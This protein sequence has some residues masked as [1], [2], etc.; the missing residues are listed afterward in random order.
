MADCKIIFENGKKVGVE[1]IDGASSPL[2]QQILNNA[3]VNSFDEAVEIY[4]N[5]YND[6][7]LYSI[8]GEK[9][10]ITLDRLEETTFRLDNLRIAQEMETQGKNPSEIRTTTSWEKGADGK[11]KLEILEGKLKISE[12]EVGV[13]YNISDILT[14]SELTLL[15][16]NI[17]I[18]F[19]ENVHSANAKGGFNPN[20]GV[21]S[22]R[23]ETF[24][25]N[26]E[27]SRRRIKNDSDLLQTILHESQHYIQRIEGFG[28]GGNISTVPRE[29]QRIIDARPTDTSE[30]LKEKAQS[31]LLSDNITNNEKNI[32]Q[33]YLGILTT[34]EPLKEA[35]E[36][37]ERLAGEVEAENVVKRMFFED[38]LRKNQLLATSAEIPKSDQIVIFGDRTEPNLRYQTPNGQIFDS[39]QDALKNT[40]DG[41]IKGGVNTLNG[42]QEFFSVE[43]NTN[44]N[45]REGIINNLVKSG[46][47]T[48]ETYVDK[49]GLTYHKPNGNSI[50]KKA[51]NGAEVVE[52]IQKH[53]GLRAVKTK[54]N[55]DVHI[56]DNYNKVAITKKNGE[57]EYVEQS[58]L[59]Q[60]NWKQ[61]EDGIALL[62][63]QEHKT[64]VKGE[65][66]EQ[67]TFVPENELQQKLMKWLTQVGIKTTSM[68]DYVENYAKKNGV[69]P[70]ASA[71]ADIANQVVAFRDGVITTAD[72]SEETAHFII[73]SMPQSEKENMLRN[74]HKTREWAEHYQTYM[75]IYQDEAMVREEIL[76]KVLANG[77]QE[78]FNARNQNSTEDSILAKLAELFQ[79]F[80][81]RIQ[82]F[83]T[84]NHE[85]QLNKFTQ[86]V[87]A[88]LMAETL[89]LGALPKQGF[90]LF[91]VDQ[92]QADQATRL[93]NKTGEALDV[94]WAQ[95]NQLAKGRKLNATRDELKEAKR[96]NQEA[97]RLSKLKALSGVVLVAKKQITHLERALEKASTNNFPFTQEENAVYQTYIS[98]TETLLSEITALLDSGNSEENII[99]KQLVEVLGKGAQL[100]GIV[101]GRGNTAIQT[102]VDKVVLK[103]N[104]TSAQ[105]K[106]F[107]GFITASQKDTNFLMSHLGSL[108]SARNPL[109]NIAGDITNRIQVE[110]RE[111]YL[112]AVKG[113]TNAL[114]KAGVEPK[115]IK[116][117]IDESGQYLINELDFTAINTAENN[118]KLEVYNTMVKEPLTLEKFLDKESKGELGLDTNQQRQYNKKV[119]D[120]TSKWREPFFKESYLKEQESLFKDLPSEALDYHK[121]YRAQLAEIRVNATQDGVTI[122]DSNDKY[123]I[124]QLNKQRAYASNPRELTGEM[125]K[126]LMETYNPQTQE[127]ELNLDVD[128][129]NKDP[130]G[131]A[132]A[133]I[134]FGLNKIAE[135]T[136]KQYEGATRDSEIPQKFF[137]EINKLKTLEERIEFMFLN[138]YVGFND[139]FWE[140]FGSSEG[141]LQKLQNLNDIENDFLI[142]QIR[143]Q[144]QKIS[145]IQKANRVF[146]RPSE[147]NVAEMEGTEKDAIKEAVQDLEALYTQAN[148]LL[149]K[150]AQVDVETLFTSTVND[151]YT[152]MLQ[153]MNII[154]LDKE[155]D[156]IQRHTS[157]NNRQNILKAMR[158]AEMLRKDSDTEIPKTLQRVFTNGMNNAEIDQALLDYSRSKLLPYYKRTEPR[159]FS[160]VM[161]QLREG[162]IT[163]EEFTKSPLVKVSPNYSFY[164]TV[165]NDN[166]NPKFLENKKNGRAQIKEGLFE[167][168]KYKDYFDVQNGEATKNKDMWEVYKAVLELQKTTLDNMGMS[169]K[170][171]LYKLPQ[172]GKRGLRQWQDTL[173]ESSGRPW[174]EILK[175][176]TTWRTDELEFGVDN[177]QNTASKKMRANIIPMYYVRD[178]QDPKDVTDE[179]LYSYALM[180]QQSALY[181]AR[182]NNI[183]D[184]LAVKQ[185]ILNQDIQGK[186]ASTSQTYQ[187]FQS[188]MDFNLYGVK[189]NFSYEV[190]LLGTGKIVD[191]S[192]VAVTFNNIIK[193]INLT[194]LTIPVVSWTQGEVQRKIESIVG[195]RINPIAAKIANAEFRKLATPAAGEI[196]KINSKSKLNVLGEAFGLYNLGER[197][198]N[199]NYGKFTRGLDKASMATHTL[200]NFPI[201]PR[202]LLTVLHDARYYDGRIMSFNQFSRMKALETK[203][204]SKVELEWKSLDLFYEDIYVKDGVQEYDTA[205]IAT[206][207]GKNE[208]ETV[209][210]LK[211]YHEGL[212]SRV[213]AAVQDIDANIPQ[214]ERS[215]ASRH[216]VF[217]FF[218]THRN[219]LLLATAR[220]FKDKH[221]NLA[222]GELEEGSYLNTY[223]FMKEITMGYRKSEQATYLKHIKDVW[224]N[225]DETTRR[226]LKRVLVDVAFVNTMMVLSYLLSNMLEDDDDP[227]WALAFT[228]YI[229]YRTTNEQVSTN[230]AL[231]RQFAEVLKTPIV[232]TDRIADMADYFDV[233]STDVVKAGTF[234]GD[235]ESWRILSRNVPGVKEYD[236]LRNIKKTRDTYE[237]HNKDNFD[238]IYTHYLLSQE[239]E[240]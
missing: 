19:E 210:Y 48:G 41:Q 1:G 237:F 24:G 122:Y 226:N 21:L 80:M 116:E 123:E 218:L 172:V 46:I 204:K 52:T 126:G 125:K 165:A 14:E 79:K 18:K 17:K 43:A 239:K 99:K 106:E 16:P 214:E 85:A 166:I 221:Y 121:K 131:T 12:Y 227:V 193:K 112:K 117:L 176:M 22:I 175:E 191:L 49:D 225:S 3:H 115:R 202:V 104:L 89:N 160:E 195:E 110:Q 111:D 228:D 238:Y 156:E 132:E 75:D 192:K 15:H 34:F 55:G 208:Q 51:M 93:Y 108:T 171:N 65:A 7:V 212:T 63:I 180:N 205:K 33:S 26:T 236:K 141:L 173:K 30:Q 77:L 183:G 94:I 155:L 158:I 188:F 150:D 40:T 190:D 84:P 153:D 109:L 161:E 120:V 57:V 203:D 230:L 6:K 201:L 60:K 103:H 194:S 47:L 231:P 184:M 211:I 88:N 234:K 215:Q 25:I 124:E 78:Q 35:T 223:T 62:G 73:A 167:N 200:M 151:A 45:T 91:S 149:P 189:Q 139:S 86:D 235:T 185:A 107:E 10:A 197:F 209:G 38:Y 179:L 144:Q 177:N 232:G 59:Q 4:S 81:D 128:A 134:A 2:F 217:N 28:V 20:D 206:K 148:K 29:A 164:E 36:A 169:E 220:R 187:M 67:A 133:R 64:V 170:Q 114:E 168:K 213:N 50:A 181:K 70:S 27:S 113:F 53:A 32:V 61:Y 102:L 37:Y 240:K 142:E 199:S 143:K 101:N 136:K 130:E 83:L 118:I 97:D 222:S 11:W 178:L 145:N 100:K 186:E 96:L 54:V 8:I 68:V 174:A 147:T 162:D 74:I 137:D 229:L 159:G 95:Q 182:V 90:T 152:E 9:G 42:F 129:I 219:W 140:S 76:G 196:L 224:E 163:V 23:S 58:E 66:Q 82:G 87:Y 154:T 56:T 5:I 138:A 233:F 146:N 207:L 119:S 135:I 198:E 69:P 39:Y 31:T 44:T 98:H 72:L 105:R 71:L 216:A 13:E 157:A 127:Y 92:T